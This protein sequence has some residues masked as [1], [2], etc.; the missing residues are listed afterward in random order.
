V[1]R[2]DGY[3]VCEVGDRGQITDPLAGRR[4]ASSGQLGGRG[5]LLVNHVADLVRIHTG[6]GGTAVRV[7]MLA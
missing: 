1:W 4:A 6:V 5:L 7:Y 2:E 3:V